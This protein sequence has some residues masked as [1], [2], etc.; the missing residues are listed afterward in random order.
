MFL[1]MFGKNT[2][3]I[4]SFEDAM[5]VLRSVNSTTVKKEEI[6][7]KTDEQLEEQMR[8]NFHSIVEEEI[9]KNCIEN[10]RRKINSSSGKVTYRLSLGNDF[11]HQFTVFDHEFFDSL[12]SY[13]ECKFIGYSPKFSAEFTVESKENIYSGKDDY[14]IHLTIHYHFC[15]FENIVSPHSD[16][17]HVE[18]CYELVNKGILPGMSLYEMDTKINDEENFDLA[19]EQNSKG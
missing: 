9:K 7:Q 12:F 10:V 3:K 8:V 15:S 14:T 13:L 2:R 1:G 18:F 17:N 19:I 6:P 16:D 4:D 5:K 11:L